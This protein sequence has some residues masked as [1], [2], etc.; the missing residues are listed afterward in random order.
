MTAM[1]RILR[2][3]HLLAPDG[4][5]HDQQLVVGADGRIERLEPASPDNRDW[6]GWLALPGMPNAH[7]H[8]FQ[9]AL[10]GYGEARKSDEDSFWSWREAMYRLAGQIAPDDLHVIA[11]QGFIDMLRA[12]F[13][14]VAEFHYL[15]HLPDGTRTRAMAD[16]VIAA[17]GETGIRLRLLPVAYFHAGFGGK[18]PTAGQVR[19]AHRNLDEYLELLQSLLPQQPGIAPHSLR[20]VPVDWLNDLVNGAESLLGNDFP[21][22]IHIAEQRREIDDCVQAHSRTPIRLLADS[23]NLNPRWQLVHATHADAEEIDRVAESGAGVVICPITE[24]Y[25]GDGLFDAV[26]FCEQGGDLSI[27]SDSNCRIDVFEELR[28]LEYGQRL[29]AE[30]RARLSDEK[31]LG[32]SLYAR[33]ASTGGNA[34]RMSVG[35]IAPGAFADLVVVDE[36]ADA[37]AGHDAST[38]LDA[39]VINGSRADVADVYVG[40]KRVIENG[41]HASAH[42]ARDSFH[43]VTKRLL[44]SNGQ[45]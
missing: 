23:V 42:V 31:G 3:R 37:L 18:A 6:D 32:E 27:G 1:N 43:C 40:G 36:S 30:R 38:A 24:A 14:S 45:G 28:L 10:A 13:T 22:H 20:A 8:V 33:C 19:F 25:L 16:A 17:A 44:K 26:H 7:S 9:R 41:S 2:F 29:R 11:R 5:L 21:I 34:L 39:L 12:G 35:A 4:M 15:H